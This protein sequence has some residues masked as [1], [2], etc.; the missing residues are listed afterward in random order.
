MTADG[1][2]I[3]FVVTAT[4]IALIVFG[5]MLF[6][7]GSVRVPGHHDHGPR[8]APLVDEDDTDEV[9]D[10]HHGFHHAA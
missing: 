9:P 7:S 1:Y 4:V 6:V 2:I 3:W 8:Q 5:G 10:T